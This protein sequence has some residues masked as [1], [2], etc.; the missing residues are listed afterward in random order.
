MPD[1]SCIKPL[2]EE[3][4]RAIRFHWGVESNNS[5]RDIT[6]DEDCIKSGQQSI[7][8]GFVTQSCY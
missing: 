7:D 6:F 3:L 1:A 4:T 5:I 8:H 2:A